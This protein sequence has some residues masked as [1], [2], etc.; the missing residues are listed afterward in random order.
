[1]IIA[2]SAC[3]AQ[4]KESELIGTYKANHDKGEDVIVLKEEG[5]YIHTFKTPEKLFEREGKWEYEI[6]MD[7][8]LISFYNFD[9]RWRD[10]Y[11]TYK[12]DE[13][14]VW[15]SFIERSIFGKIRLG[16]SADL[17]YYYEKVES[18]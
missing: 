12:K 18:E 6:F 4:F 1:M 8:P 13:K 14:N 16:L 2:L 9:H 11:Y 5:I 3:E 17:D 15:P 7:Q 10:D